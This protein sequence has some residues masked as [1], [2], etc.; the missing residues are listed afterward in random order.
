VY[1]LPMQAVVE[2]VLAKKVVEQHALLEQEG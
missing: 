2:V 1:L